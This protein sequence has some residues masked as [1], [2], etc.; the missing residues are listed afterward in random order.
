MR[1][2]SPQC[3][4]TVFPRQLQTLPSDKAGVDNPTVAKDMLQMSEQPDIVGAVLQASLR[5]PVQKENV[6]AAEAYFTGIYGRNGGE[7]G[8]RAKRVGKNTCTISKSPQTKVPEWRPESPAADTVLDGASWGQ[9]L[10]HMHATNTDR[11]SKQRVP[12]FFS[13]VNVVI[14]TLLL[15]DVLSTSGA[16]RSTANKRD[17][18]YIVS[19]FMFRPGIGGMAAVA[20]RVRPAR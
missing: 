9:E 4:Q 6:E 14:S 8:L 15:A 3:L 17:L 7:S 5:F 11:S 16:P 18:Q 1:V 10:R 13:P 12:C 20:L 2:F 19:G